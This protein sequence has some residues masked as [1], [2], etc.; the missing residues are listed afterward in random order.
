MPDSCILTYV[1]SSLP[2]SKIEWNKISIR[3]SKTF[4]YYDP[5][6]A[7]L[8]KL[9]PFY[10]Q[11]F[12]TSRLIFTLEKISCK[13]GFC[14]IYKRQFLSSSPCAIALSGLRNC[15]MKT[16][17]TPRLAVREIDSDSGGL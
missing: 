10:M 3:K 13:H 15:R 8:F 11:E 9:R 16:K 12:G 4:L 17:Q 2:I 5:S 7:W 1:Y 14:F 6:H